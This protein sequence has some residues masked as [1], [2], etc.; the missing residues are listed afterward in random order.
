MAVLTLLA[1]RYSR[2]WFDRVTWSSRADP[3]TR[4]LAG[5]VITVVVLGLG[6]F[7]IL[8]T[9]GVPPTAV[10]TFVGA[11]GLALSLSTQEILKNFFSGVY[12]LF[13]R[14]FR[15]G[16]EIVVKGER[17]RVEHV[18]VRTTTLR[19]DENVEVLIPNAVMFAEI[20]FNR[21]NYRPKPAEP[22]AEAQPG[23]RTTGAD[24]PRPEQRP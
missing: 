10:V 16:D 3:G 13:E 20:V 24:A 11:V 2:R 18:G 1:I 6:V 12:L 8:D 7:T 22:A 17:G 5:R 19:T 21:S 15:I 4:L 9:L 14:P 23:P